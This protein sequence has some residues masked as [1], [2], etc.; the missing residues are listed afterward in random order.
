MLFIFYILLHVYFVV[1]AN[2]LD[3]I[4]SELQLYY[5]N[6]KKHIKKD[7]KWK[8]GDLCI[9]QYHHDKKWYRGKI[10]ANLGD[11]VKVNNNYLFVI[12]N[13]HLHGVI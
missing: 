8:K 7:K 2:V 12:C 10:V 4:D 5:K 6:E 11:I 13:Y 1:G 9:A 3:Y